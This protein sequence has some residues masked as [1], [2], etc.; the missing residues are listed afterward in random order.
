MT[1]PFPVK[2]CVC[3]DVTFREVAATVPNDLEE[4]KIRFGCGSSCGACIPYLLLML[5]TGKV[6]FAP[7][8]M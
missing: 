5:E 3:H 7:F 6:E 8:E 4:I 2:K 1:D